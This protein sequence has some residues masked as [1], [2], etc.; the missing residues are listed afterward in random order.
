MTAPA[1][2][3]MAYTLHDVD[4][5]VRLVEALLQ[6]VRT[7]P[8]MLIAPAALLAH[9]RALAPRDALLARAVPLGLMPKLQL[10]T[11]FCRQHGYPDLGAL[12]GTD[13]ANG[14]APH[15]D[16]PACLAA[17]WSLAP[18]RLAAAAK[19]WRAAVPARLK[20]R[21]ERPA[22][23]AWYAWFRTHRADCAH[24]TAEGKH[25]IIN[26]VMAGLD[27]ETALRRVLAAQ[28]TQGAAA[29]GD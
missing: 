18:A 5:A 23:V 16:G 29:M 21:A 26:L 13:A 28:A 4:V 7:A 19:A 2:P 3:A 17:D 10:V 20:P 14:P 9:A 15:A 11:Q 25:E 8:V 6:Y 27:P 1:A 24:V 22:D 12:A